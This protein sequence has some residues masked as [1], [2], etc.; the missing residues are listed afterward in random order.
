ML[1][2]TLLLSGC[3]GIRGTVPDAGVVSEVD[4]TEPGTAGR[5]P[6]GFEPVRAILCDD[7]GTVTDG[8]GV[9]SGPATR[10]VEGD[11]TALIDAL[12]QAD[13]PRWPGPCTAMEAIAPQVWL[14]DAD[15]RA[16]HVTYPVD[17]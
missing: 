9:W 17:G 6:D 12:N 13:D 15:G 14:A 8:D 1:A 4:C 10:H 5:I 7:V 16:V 3:A 2:M 11:L